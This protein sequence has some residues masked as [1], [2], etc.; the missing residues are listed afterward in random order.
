ML[1]HSCASAFLLC[2]RP[3]II[4]R[5]KPSKLNLKLIHLI[6]EQD[7]KAEVVFDQPQSWGEK[8]LNLVKL[9][10]CFREKEGSFCLF[11]QFYFFHFTAFILVHSK[12]GRLQPIQADRE[13][14]KLNNTHHNDCTGAKRRN[15]AKVVKGV[16]IHLIKKVHVELHYCLKCQRVTD[17]YRYSF[18]KMNVLE[19]LTL[20]FNAWECRKSVVSK[21]AVFWDSTVGGVQFHKTAAAQHYGTATNAELLWIRRHF[22]RHFP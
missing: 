7:L 11:F 10:K 12:S 6:E 4:I 18:C 15:L 22:F 14:H 21:W 19:E 13:W 16:H 3:K 1:W 20:N 17:R 2:N 5:K 8:G 9:L